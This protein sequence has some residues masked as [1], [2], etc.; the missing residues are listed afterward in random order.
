MAAAR[1]M[2]DRPKDVPN[3]TIEVARVARASM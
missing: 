1:Q 3:S 2:V